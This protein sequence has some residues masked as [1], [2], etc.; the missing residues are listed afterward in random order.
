M[1]PWNLGLQE[2]L[3][4]VLGPRVLPWSGYGLACPQC[5]ETVL[6]GRVG[7]GV[8]ALAAARPGP[9]GGD[10]P[11]T[12]ALLSLPPWGHLALIWVHGAAPNLA[13]WVGSW[14]PSLPWQPLDRKSPAEI[15]PHEGPCWPLR[16]PSPR[17]EP[18]CGDSVLLAWE[19]LVL[20]EP[21]HLS[22]GVRHRHGMDVW[23]QTQTPRNG[24]E[25]DN[26]CVTCPRAR[27]RTWSGGPAGLGAARGTRAPRGCAAC[28]RRGQSC[29]EQVGRG[30]GGGQQGRHRA[31]T[32][33]LAEPQE[34]GNPGAH[35]MG[36]LPS[37]GWRRRGI[38]E[39][40]GRVPACAG[41]RT[42]WPL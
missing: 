8:A 30:C 31:P 39:P 4:E 15:S 34:V 2:S 23:G 13:L 41:V 5:P 7:K 3:G 12:Q 27:V 38:R 20:S 10:R 1:V 19:T 16:S 29:S 9:P 18:G 11:P 28:G 14:V 33:A 35:L 40:Q 25:G 26:R 32:T 17:S 22:W 36:R 6:S 21:P 42:R 24:M 37:S